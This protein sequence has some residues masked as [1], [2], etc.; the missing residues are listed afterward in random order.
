MGDGETLR[1]AYMK[2]M[3]AVELLQTMGE[4]LL[5]DEAHAVA[6]KVGR[7]ALAAAETLPCKPA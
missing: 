3:D 4:D 1:L 5:A 2:V 6:D 7:A